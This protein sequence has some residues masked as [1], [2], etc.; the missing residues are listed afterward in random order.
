VALIVMR[1]AKA[2]GVDSDSFSRHSLRAGFVTSALAD[3]ADRFKVMDVTRHREVKTLKAYAAKGSR[4]RF[5]LLYAEGR[6]GTGGPV[7]N[8]ARANLRMSF[9]SQAALPSGL[10]NSRLCE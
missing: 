5:F 2:A 6:L 10:P 4:D 7:F 9:G 8:A 1:W 3:G